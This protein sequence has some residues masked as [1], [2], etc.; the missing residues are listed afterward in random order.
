MV[1]KGCRIYEKNQDFRLI[2]LQGAF[3]KQWQS[4]SW[5]EGIP[6]RTCQKAFM[7]K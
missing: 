6:S 7:L 2:G 4:W 5:T 3:L 1:Y